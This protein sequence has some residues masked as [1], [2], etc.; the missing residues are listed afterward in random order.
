MGLTLAPELAQKQSWFWTPLQSFPLGTPPKPI[1]QYIN[2]INA[3]Q[4]EQMV[5][6]SSLAQLSTSV[7]GKSE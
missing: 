4:S 5:C 2:M 6:V 1:K 7:G 3:N